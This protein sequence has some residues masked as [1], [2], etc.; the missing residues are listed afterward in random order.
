MLDY[1]K[2]LV[3]T[4]IAVLD[5]YHFDISAAPLKSNNYA[6]RMKRNKKKRGGGKMQVC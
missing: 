4:V 3:R 1:Q 2:Q 5:A 6:P